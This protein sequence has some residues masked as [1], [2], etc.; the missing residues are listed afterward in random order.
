MTEKEHNDVLLALYH[1]GAADQLDI[2]NRYNEALSKAGREAL[3]I[4]GVSLI[5]SL[6]FW[7]ITTFVL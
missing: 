7:L 2:Q 6:G 3:Y 4:G 5:A 1:S